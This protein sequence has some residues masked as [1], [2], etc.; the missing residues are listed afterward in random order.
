MIL[1]KIGIQ[2]RGEE[3]IMACV[4]NVQYVVCDQWISNTVFWCYEGAQ[5]GVLYFALTFYLAMDDLNLQIKKVI[6]TDNS[7]ALVLGR[8]IKISHNFFVDYVLIMGMIKRIDCFVLYH[9]FKRFEN[10]LSLIMNLLKSSILYGSCN[11]DDI[12][13][14]QNLFGI[15]EDSLEGGTT[16]LGFHIKPCRYRNQDWMWLVDKFYKNI[17]RW[18]FKC[19]SLVGR[20]TLTQFFITQ[21]RFY[22]AHLYHLPQAIIQHLIRL[23]TQFIWPGAYHT[24]IIWLDWNRPPCQNTWVDRVF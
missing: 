1:H 14:I 20:V 22:W 21:L 15:G 18:E 24:N 13:Y 12:A 10:A 9:I 7:R 19:L 4:T 5:I 23:M 16:Y 17:T 3:W 6:E 11:M 8:D 2:T